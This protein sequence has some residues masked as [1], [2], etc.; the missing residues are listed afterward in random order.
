MWWPAVGS[1]PRCRGLLRLRGQKVYLASMRPNIGNRH[2]AR[3]SISILHPR[4]VDA[5]WGAPLDRDP[6][7]AVRSTWCTN[8]SARQT[9]TSPVS[10][11]VLLIVVVGV[12]FSAVLSTFVSM[13]DCISITAPAIR[14]CKMAVCR[15]NSPTATSSAPVGLRR[16]AQVQTLARVRRES[17]DLDG[18]PF[19]DTC[20]PTKVS[21][22][23]VQVERLRLP[24]VPGWPLSARSWTLTSVIPSNRPWPPCFVCCCVLRRNNR[25]D[26]CLFSVVSSTPLPCPRYRFAP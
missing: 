24:L 4:A 17:V 26:P 20:K 21:V 6:S 9:R 12:D 8:K 10:R 22:R 2:G 25:R 23:D 19:V 13:A 15:A 5:C 16:A 11:L 7:T 3:C 18:N 14:P 1:L